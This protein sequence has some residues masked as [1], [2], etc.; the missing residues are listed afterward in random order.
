MDTVT[1]SQQEAAGGK[2]TRARGEA[3]G[4]NRARAYRRTEGRIRAKKK[5]TAEADTLLGTTVLC[6]AFSLKWKVFNKVINNPKKTL[7]INSSNT[8]EKLKHNRLMFEWVRRCWAE[9]SIRAS[10][11]MS[12]GNS[13][14]HNST[15][16]SDVPKT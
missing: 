15:S 9:I 1:D 11:R 14:A 10:D 16:P 3:R 6:F 2:L 12:R 8:A 7:V 5:G 4:S 13:I